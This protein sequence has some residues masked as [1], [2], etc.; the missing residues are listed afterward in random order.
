MD[1]FMMKTHEGFDNLPETF[2]PFTKKDS[3]TSTS[4]SVCDFKVVKYQ[5]HN[6]SNC[7]KPVCSSCIK[8]KKRL[9]KNDEQIYSVCDKCDFDIAHLNLEKSLK[10]AEVCHEKTE[11][12]IKVELK[13]C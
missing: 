9:S 6:C 3:Y 5:N 10:T 11:M 8:T 2:T 1:I 12:R 7:G 13:K 4:C